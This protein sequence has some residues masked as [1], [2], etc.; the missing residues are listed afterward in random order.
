MLVILNKKTVLIGLLLVFALLLSLTSCEEE[1]DYLTI[2]IY[3]ESGAEINVTVEQK[4]WNSQT[5]VYDTPG[6]NWSNVPHKGSVRY[7]G[8]SGDTK[9]TITQNSNS[10]Y[11]PK[12][13]GAENYKKMAGE[14]SFVFDGAGIKE[15]GKE[16]L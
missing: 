5:G 12:G 9:F 15:G 8:N 13:G 10:F 16:E 7:E 6:G 1:E 3:N 11:F 2:Y 4:L 14:Y